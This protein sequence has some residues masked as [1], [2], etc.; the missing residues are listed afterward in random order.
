MMGA[1]AVAV[2]VVCAAMYTAFEARERWKRKKFAEDLRRYIKN[3][4][5]EWN[6]AD[7]SMR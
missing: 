2:V 3:H 1:V 7:E 4:K 6:D 5:G